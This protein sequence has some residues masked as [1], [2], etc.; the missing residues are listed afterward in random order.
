M[1]ERE[2][3]VSYDVTE[4]QIVLQRSGEDPQT[5]DPA[6]VLDLRADLLAAGVAASEHRVLRGDE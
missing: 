5:V 6:E 1:T 4:R 2:W 3:F